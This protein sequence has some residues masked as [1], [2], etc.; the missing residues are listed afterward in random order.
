[1]KEAWGASICGK[2][3]EAE[4]VHGCVPTGDATKHNQ[5][6]GALQ[7]KTSTF[8]K[9]TVIPPTFHHL[10]GVAAAAA[11]AVVAVA[12]AAAAAIQHCVTPLA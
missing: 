3:N 7:F 10:C 5:T 11:V 6:L 8:P 4:G 12:V 1:M 2:E 9:H